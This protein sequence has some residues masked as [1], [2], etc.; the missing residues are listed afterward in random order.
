VFPYSRIA[1]ALETAA[2]MSH[3]VVEIVGPAE[4]GPTNPD[5]RSVSGSRL[6]FWFVPTSKEPTDDEADRAAKCVA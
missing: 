2:M 4:A 5:G 3:F 6:I 1:N